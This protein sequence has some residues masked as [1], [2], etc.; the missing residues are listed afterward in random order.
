MNLLLTFLPALL[1]LLFLFLL[2]SFKLVRVQTL[3]LCVVWGVLCTLAGYVL[4]TLA[5]SKLQLDFD[6]L[7][8]Y[9]SPVIEETLKGL[10]VYYLI[11][12]KKIGFMIDAVIYGFAIGTGFSL[13]ENIYYTMNAPPENNPLIWIVRGFGTAFMH[14]GCTSLLALM[15]MVSINSY[16]MKILAFLPGLFLAILLHSGFNHFPLNPMLQTLLIM[17]LLPM[18]FAVIFMISNKKL[19]QWLEI[20]FNSEVDLLY[21]IRKGEFGKTKAG[22]YLLS[23]KSHFP[24]ETL[25]DMYCYIGLYLELSIKAKR[26]LMLQENGFPIVVEDDILPKL[27]ELAQLRRQ[28]GKVG[29]MALSPLIRMNYRNLWQLNQLKG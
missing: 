1:F 13:V 2:D 23:I 18:M 24:P 10:F 15:F 22:D 20:E 8:R 4:N 12:K 7:S 26:N 17:V 3:I 29:E 14:G 11:T 9:V 27:T 21:M 6:F 28:I 5:A 16:S 19:Q 25:V